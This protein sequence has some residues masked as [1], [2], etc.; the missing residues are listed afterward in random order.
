MSDELSPEM[1]KEIKEALF[2]LAKTEFGDELN[3]LTTKARERIVKHGPGQA[4]ADL[5][6]QLQRDYDQAI[7]PGLLAMTLVERAPST[8][9]APTPWTGS[10]CAK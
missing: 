9:F 7:L 6:L 5:V 3:T 4:L 8:R 1:K 2:D 10:G